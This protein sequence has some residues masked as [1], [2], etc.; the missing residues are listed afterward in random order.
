MLKM[1]KMMNKSDRQMLII[2]ILTTCIMLACISTTTAVL[3]SIA[4][5]VE[6]SFTIGKINLELTET[7]GQSYQLIPGKTVDKNP[8]VTVFAG[9]ESCWLFIKVYK[10]AN[11]DDYL[12]YEIAEGWNILDGQDGVY[13]RSVDAS[14]ITVE[15]NVLAND[16]II[17]KD[18]LTE[19]KMSAITSAPSISFYAYGIQSYN[20]ETALDAW[21]LITEEGMVR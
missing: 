14:Q 10:T 17:V 11:F 2:S 6:N 3:T 4:K 5:P 16:Q 9:S 7:T 12:T 15:H 20:V 21:N 1:L 8:K 13:Y 18:D 19:E